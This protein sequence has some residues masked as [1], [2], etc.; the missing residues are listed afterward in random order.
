MIQKIGK[1]VPHFNAKNSKYKTSRFD[2]WGG[3]YIKGR[4]GV[5]NV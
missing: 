1:E 5:L 3:L 2:I 4:F